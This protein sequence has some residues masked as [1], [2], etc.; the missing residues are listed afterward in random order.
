MYVVTTDLHRRV[1]RE[2]DQPN[3]VVPL[4]TA[5]VAPG[6]DEREVRR[7]G[8]LRGRRCGTAPRGGRRCGRERRARRPRGDVGT[9]GGRR[10]RVRDIS[11]PGRCRDG[12]PRGRADGRHSSP[13]ALR[14][15]SGR[16]A[17][18]AERDHRSTQP[19]RPAI[20]TTPAV[21]T[22]SVTRLSSSCSLRSTRYPR[23]APLVPGEPPPSVIGPSVLP[24]TALGVVHEGRIRQAWPLGGIP[25][26]DDGQVVVR[27]TR[28]SDAS[29]P[30]ADRSDPTGAAVCACSKSPPRTPG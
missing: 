5:V 14:R 12:Q 25:S 30:T 11:R 4:T 2:A 16:R 6:A 9:A 21:A 28:L 27:V 10:R 8:S 22:P 29:T 15:C 7:V 20:R 3:P 1:S 13:G 19:A 24:R 26:H 18:A 17:G 23:R